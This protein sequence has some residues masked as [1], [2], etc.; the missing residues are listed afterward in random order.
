MKIL[1]VTA[2]ENGLFG[3]RYLL[4]SGIAVTAVLTIS[5]DVQKTAR[6]SG[7]ADVTDY[8]AS[9]GIR[10]LTLDN[11]AVKPQDL[12]GQKYDLLLVNGWNRLI[13]EE[14]LALFPLGGLGIHAGHPPIGLGRAPASL[15]HHQGL[16]GYR[17]LCVSLDSPC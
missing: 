10:V 9:Q 3:L 17:G 15:E 8:C 6:V 16:S 13:S 12:Q 2:G 4:E 14:V 7:F 11:Y 5:N 1:Y